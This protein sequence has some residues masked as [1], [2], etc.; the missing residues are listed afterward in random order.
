MATRVLYSSHEPHFLHGPKRKA[1]FKAPFPTTPQPATEVSSTSYTIM[2]PQNVFV[3]YTHPGQQNDRRRR[4]EVA[5]Y[6]GTYFRNRSRPAAKRE[7]ESSLARGAQHEQAE[8]L[9]VASS[10][11]RPSALQMFNWRLEP[12]GVSP[13]ALR[14]GTGLRVDPFSSYP[15]QPT[16]ALPKALDYFFG[17][18]A[19]THLLRSN[20]GP[21]QAPQKLIQNYVRYAM[22]HP[23]MFESIITLS[24]A[25][26]HISQWVDG[27]PDI[28]TARHYGSTLK[29]LREALSVGNGLFEDA[30]FLAI[31]GLINAEYLLGNVNAYRAHTT[32]MMYIIRYRGGLN[33]IGW[34][35]IT[36]PVVAGM[37]AQC[38][39]Y[40]NTS[41]EKLR[42]MMKDKSEDLLEPSIAALT[43]QAPFC[44]FPP[45]ALPPGLQ[46]LAS[47]GRITDRVFHLAKLTMN[48]PCIDLRHNNAAANTALSTELTAYLEWTISLG[49]SSL[50][51]GILLMALHRELYDLGS[52]ERYSVFYEDVVLHWTR[53]CLAVI[54]RIDPDDEALVEM[55]IWTCFKHSGTMVAP[56][57]RMESDDPND[58]RMQLMVRAF[59]KFWQT[60][61]WPFCLELLLRFAPMR[62]CVHWWHLIWERTMKLY[63]GSEGEPQI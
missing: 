49:S 27:Q 43:P 14:D 22:Q 52:A 31:L 15:I 26:M 12:S 6:I 46:R 57:L 3:N 17:A 62:E 8:G 56:F 54:D 9:P 38:Q 16:A 36:T 58:L 2:K 30:T 50:A 60:R 10:S 24:Y 45:K 7:R 28:D 33:A 47:D 39:F 37:K 41:S 48:T 23:V 13:L 18:Y 34:Q 35:D 32:A 20:L 5:S 63:E 44:N 1:F 4:R 51:D 11:S 55:F 42:R 40:I 21:E 29:S 59:Q 25:N 53:E 19:P 61:E